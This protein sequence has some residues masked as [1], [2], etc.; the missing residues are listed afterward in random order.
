LNAYTKKLK[1]AVLEIGLLELT[2]LK[3]VLY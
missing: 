2:I 1:I 3:D